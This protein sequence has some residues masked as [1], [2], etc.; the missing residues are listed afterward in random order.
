M[1]CWHGLQ[2]TTTNNNNWNAEQFIRSEKL[3]IEN[4]LL[5]MVES[6]WWLIV[7]IV[8]LK[9]WY[10]KNVVPQSINQSE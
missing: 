3:G 8:E 6:E 9:R 10:S 4:I 7:E 1:V 5:P 2:S